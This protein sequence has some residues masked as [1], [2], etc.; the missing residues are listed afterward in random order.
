M[1]GEPPAGAAPVAKPDTAAK[2][3]E[4]VEELFVPEWT[5]IRVE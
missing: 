4:D 1:P 3:S 5:R 2:P